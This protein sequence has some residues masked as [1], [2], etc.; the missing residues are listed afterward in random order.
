MQCGIIGTTGVPD[1][2][3][4]TVTEEHGPFAGAG[5]SGFY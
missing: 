5:S 3:N 2:D 4:G 1:K